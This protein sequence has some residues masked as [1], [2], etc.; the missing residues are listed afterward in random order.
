MCLLWFTKIKIN[1]LC[2]IVPIVVNSQKQTYCA[3]MCLMWFTKIKINLLCPIVPI[4]V[5][6]KKETY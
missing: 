3:L 1:L 6:Q 4:V 2:P 5:N